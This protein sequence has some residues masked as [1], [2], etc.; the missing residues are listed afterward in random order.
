MHNI[1]SRNQLDQW[2]H[3]GAIE[4]RLDSANDDLDRVNDYYECLIECGDD[5]ATC[6]RICKEILMDQYCYWRGLK[7]LFFC[8]NTYGIADS[9]VYR[10][11][12]LQRKSDQCAA[13]WHEWY[14]WRFN[15]SEDPLA[16]SVAKELR[17]KWCQCADELGE[18]IQETLR[19]DPRYERWKE[20][21]NL[22][23][24]P[25]PRYNNSARVQEDEQS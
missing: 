1:I 16:P 18:M 3:L 22:D 20:M 25:D 7:P 13:L 9:Y 17:S 14:E 5:Q 6:K 21:M 2:M 15:R 23:K 11:P 24:K 19:T 12:H 10:E 4:D 8:V